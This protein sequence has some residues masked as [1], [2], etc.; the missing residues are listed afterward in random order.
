MS[1]A[2][3]VYSLAERTLRMNLAKK[4]ETIPN[5]INNPTATPTLRWVFQCLEG[6]HVVFLPLDAKSTAFIQGITDLRRRILS[7]FGEGV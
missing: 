4:N 7:L 6:I 2:L 1:C 5:Q 3:L